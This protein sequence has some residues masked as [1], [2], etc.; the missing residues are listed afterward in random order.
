MHCNCVQNPQSAWLKSERGLST[1]DNAEQV[2]VPS[3][4]KPRSRLDELSGNISF[5]AGVSVNSN[6][7]PSSFSFL[8]KDLKKQSGSNSVASSTNNS[9]FPTAAAKSCLAV[10]SQP[11][12]PFAVQSSGSATPNTSNAGVKRPVSVSC[13][14]HTEGTVNLLALEKEQKKLKKKKLS[15]S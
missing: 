14:P 12:T 5:N 10:P 1:L 7:K 15:F 9:P 11:T 6:S 2:E 8:G 3:S 4:S 13:T